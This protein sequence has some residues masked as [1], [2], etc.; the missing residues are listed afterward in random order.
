MSATK[1]PSTS[2]LR[3]FITSRPYVTI[4]ELRRRFGLDDP[5]GIGHLERNGTRAW[6]G[7]PE[8][9]AA[10]IQDL[11]QRDEV[12][13]ELSVEVHAPVVVGIYPMRIARYAMGSISSNATNGHAPLHGLNGPPSATGANG[14]FPPYAERPHGPPATGPMQGTPPRLQAGQHPPE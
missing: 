3:R 6:I 13:L 14:R 2:S 8:R 11:W 10:K 5:D 9:E 1:R 4:A 7:L 12:G